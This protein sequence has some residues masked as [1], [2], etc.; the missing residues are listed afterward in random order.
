M[1]TNVITHHLLL[2]RCMPGI[3]LTCPL[4]VLGLHLLELQD[5]Q[6][7]Q[8]PGDACAG[9]AGPAPAT[10]SEAHATDPSSLGVVEWGVVVSTQGGNLHAKEGG[11]P[12]EEQVRVRVRPPPPSPPHVHTLIGISTF[13]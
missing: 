1:K 2:N 4:H 9:D 5:Q 3:L 6:Q 10:H 11:V 7:Q 12:Y 8:P 13:L